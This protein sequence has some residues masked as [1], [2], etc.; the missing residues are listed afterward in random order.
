MPVILVID[1]DP[2]VAEAI[3]LVLQDDG[4]EV[5]CAGTARQ[6]VAILRSGRRFDLLL[7]D[8]TLAGEADAGLRV[9][10]AARALHPRI[11]VIYV[12]ATGAGPDLRLVEGARYLEKPFGPGPLADAVRSLAGP[13]P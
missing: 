5:V 7:T 11:H 8:L 6:A 10:V 4:H 1:D 2:F 9:A 13:P 12:S 3:S